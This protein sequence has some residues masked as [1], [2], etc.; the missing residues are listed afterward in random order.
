MP[1]GGSSSM[2][3]AASV[4][5]AARSLHPSVA[6]TSVSIA[7][8]E[9]TIGA[10]DDTGYWDYQHRVTTRADLGQK[11]RECKRTF[12]KLGEP[13]TE[14]RGA[15]ISMRYHAECFSGFADPRSQATSSMHVGGLAGTQLEAAPARK[16]GSKMRAGSHFDSAS[17]KRSADAPA[18]RSAASGKLAGYSV[19]GGGFGAKSSKGV[20]QVRETAPGDLTE[21]A[22]ARHLQQL[23][24]ADEPGVGGE[25]IR[26]AAAPTASAPD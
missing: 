3:D 21:G 10:G 23:G 18:S 1:D 5:S 13:L 12:Q 17:D 4:A 2:D 20:E 14:R 8:S 15:R 7:C 19:H 16:A 26:T 24:V 6:N 9:V 22:L 25:G 11:C